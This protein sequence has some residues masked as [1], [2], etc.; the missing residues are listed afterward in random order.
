M[1]QTLSLG[2][3][4]HSTCRQ[5]VASQGRGSPSGSLQCRP[6]QSWGVPSAGAQPTRT[7]KHRGTGWAAAAGGTRLPRGQRPAGSHPGGASS[8]PGANPALSAE[9]VT[10][11]NTC[12]LNTDVPRGSVLTTSPP[13]KLRDHVLVKLFSTF[14]T[15][16]PAK[17]A[18]PLTV[19]SPLQLSRFS[20]VFMPFS[21]RQ[22]DLQTLRRWSTD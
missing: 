6:A 5:S 16:W 2:C 15:L 11:R 14:I 19:P 10:S 20:H 22:N 17:R 3:A 4:G 9:A 7:R 12:L 21:T 18:C 1:V 8:V 13:S